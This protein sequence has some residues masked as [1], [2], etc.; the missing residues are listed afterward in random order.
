[1]IPVTLTAGI[2]HHPT[3]S[4]SHEQPVRASGGEPFEPGAPLIHLDRPGVERRD[5]VR[6]HIVEEIDNSG[7]I[8]LIPD[9]NIN[10]P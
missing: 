4:S 3:V 5:R 8:T 9:Y 1:M 10:R 6:R 2:A 7:E